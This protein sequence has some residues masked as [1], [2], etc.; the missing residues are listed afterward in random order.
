MRCSIAAGAVA[1]C[2]LQGASAVSNGALAR[3]LSMM[4]E[5]GLLPDGTPMETEPLVADIK[6]AKIS[7]AAPP[8]PPNEAIVPEYVELP[9]DNFAKNGDYAEEGTFFNRYWVAQSAYKPGGPVFLYDAGEASAA[10]NALFR[11]TNSTS[12]FKQIVDKYN[13]IGIV[14]EHRYCKVTHHRCKLV[15][16][17]AVQ[18]ATRRPAQSMSIPHPR[19]SSG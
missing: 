17:D 3:K 15:L 12:F 8:P 14:W 11:L 9:L 5:M 4:A 19:S 6:L 7:A 16:T 10:P 13:G 2:L 18:M 1:L